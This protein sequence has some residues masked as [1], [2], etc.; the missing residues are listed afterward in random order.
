[1]PRVSTI[2]AYPLV[3][4]HYQKYRYLENEQGQVKPPEPVASYGLP[5]YVNAGEWQQVPEAYVTSQ[6][7]RDVLRYIFD[8]T[9][10]IRWAECQVI[11]TQ[12]QDQKNGG[13]CK[14]YEP[15]NPLSPPLLCQQA[16]DYT[17]P[18]RSGHK[19][20]S[21]G[22]RCYYYGNNHLGRKA[23]YQVYVPARSPDP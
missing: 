23:V 7:A 11:R 19:K 1:M 9:I 12:Y 6:H 18:V 4:Q 14:H 16:R 13:R 2:S 17:R 8:F 21:H 5:E 22:Q 20:S 10:A 3:L 15:T